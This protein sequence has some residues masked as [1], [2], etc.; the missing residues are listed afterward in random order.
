MEDPKDPETCNIFAMLKLFASAEELEEW[1]ERYKAGGMGYGHVKKRVVEL[2]D[3]HFGPFRE[4]RVELEKDIDY[5]KDV[6]S[7]G[8]AR[9][10]AVA[11]ET[12]ES[13]RRVVGLRGKC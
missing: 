6:L 5:V 13:V 4:R 9:A 2:Y 12:L 7:S 10:K 3:E 11:A 1:K 8:A